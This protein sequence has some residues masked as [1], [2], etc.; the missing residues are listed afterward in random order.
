MKRM[1]EGSQK[2]LTA[3]S[4]IS[5]VGF[6]LGFLV[7]VSTTA[8]ISFLSYTDIQGTTRE[9]ALISWWRWSLHHS[10]NMS[11]RQ[12]AFHNIVLNVLLLVALV[13]SSYAFFETCFIHMK[14]IP[15]I[16]GK[17]TRMK[18][19]TNKKMA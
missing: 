6:L 2:S 3:V 8:L 4:I 11:S 7:S 15:V 16:L 13:F 1:A 10:D 5:S 9:V 12:K 18:H 17:T 19:F 14:R